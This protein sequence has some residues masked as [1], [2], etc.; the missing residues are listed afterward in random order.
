MAIV[1]IPLPYV[2][3]NGTTADA[4][5]VNADLNQ[6]AN[7]VNA[8]AAPLVAPTFTGGATVGGGL[9][10]SSGGAGITGNSNVLGQFQVVTGPLTCTGQVGF[11]TAATT[12]TIDANNRWI[13]GGKTQPF[14]RA[15]RSTNQIAGTQVIFDT[16]ASSQ[17]V[18]TGAG[19]NY[20]N[21]TGLFTAPVAGTYLVTYSVTIVNNTGSAQNTTALLLRLNGATFVNNAS[22]GALPAGQT[23]T[24][25]ATSVIYLNAA[26][27]IAVATSVSFAA[28]YI[29]A[30]NGQQTSLSIVQLF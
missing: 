23:F 2:F 7:N 5:Q 16:V 26:D 24:G 14:F 22:A 20:D 29:V 17:G 12:W 11:G 4:T 28:N 13:N 9:T 19:A 6:I 8:N 15:Y 30:G 25:N 18:T 21:T 27:T 1:T 3:S 10:V